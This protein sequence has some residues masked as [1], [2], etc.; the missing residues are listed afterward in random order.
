MNVVAIDDEPGILFVLNQSF[1]YK[2]GMED[3]DI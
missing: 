3:Y 1:I 2:N